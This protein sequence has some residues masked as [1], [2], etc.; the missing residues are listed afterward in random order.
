FLSADH[1]VA[2]V[3]GFLKEHNIPAGNTDMLSLRQQMNSAMKDK[4]GK[5]NLIVST[6]NYQFYLNHIAIDSA[7]LNADEIKNWII[8]Y[9]SPQ[10]GIARVF[11]IDK[12]MQTTLN[13]TQKSMLA[14]G[15][16][17]KRSG[18]IQIILQPQY[19]DGF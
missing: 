9:L 10:Q 8:D 19:I 11:A 18:D 17:P 5:D 13:V 7:R 16:Y 15:Y 6:D 2:H 12:L 3:P 4:F 14:N 1:G